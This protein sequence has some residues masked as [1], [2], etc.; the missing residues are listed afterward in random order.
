MVSRKLASVIILLAVVGLPQAT[1][2]GAPKALHFSVQV[3][4]NEL[5]AERDNM[6]RINVTNIGDDVYDVGLT[7][8]LTP[9]LIMSG[10]NH[11][12]FSYLRS[13]NSVTMDV[14]LRAPASAIKSTVSATMNMQYKELGYVYYGTE[15]HSIGFSIYGWV[16]VQVFDRLLEPDPANPGSTV[17]VSGSILNIGNTPA[18]YSNITI[19]NSTQLQLTGE[20]SSYIG[21]IDPNSPF[22]FSLSAA[23]LPE[24]ESGSHELEV[25]LNYQDGR[26]VWHTDVVTMAYEISV[27]NATSQPETTNI[28]KLFLRNI[29][30]VVGGT[31]VVILVATALIIRRVRRR[32]RI[33]IDRTAPS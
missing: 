21:Q 9:P 4:G 16:Q 19:R 32:S 30:Y 24:V 29:P 11:W 5:V 8:V 14:L 27:Q 28:M 12:Y 6:L 31:L 23:V 2:V 17:T 26:Y 20:S 13:R 15:D 33:E 7:L 18:M 22:P 25:E 1:L 10:D 3:S